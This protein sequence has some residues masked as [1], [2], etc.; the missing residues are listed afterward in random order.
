LNAFIDGIFPEY[1]LR[2]ADNG[3]GFDVK[4][5]E[6][7]SAAKKRMGI[8]SM[9]ERIN[10]FQGRM[11]IWSR[12]MKGAKIRIKIPLM[13]HQVFSPGKQL[14]RRESPVTH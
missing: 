12:P 3:R 5:Q 11:T 2:I 7:L 6:L 4:A 1:I 9:Q 10:L 14:H 8:L 13:T